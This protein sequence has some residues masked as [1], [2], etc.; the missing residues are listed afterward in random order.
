MNS[1][2]GFHKI[3]K[4]FL[5]TTVDFVSLLENVFVQNKKY[6]YFYYDAE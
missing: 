4:I 5:C 6:F 2:L 1:L 3:D